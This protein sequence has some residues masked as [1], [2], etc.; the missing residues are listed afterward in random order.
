MTQNPFSVF[1]R[2]GILLIQPEKF[3]GTAIDTDEY[4]E[5]TKDDLYT[6]VK[7]KGL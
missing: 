2:G 5:H 1:L 7:R 6:I 4:F 3:S